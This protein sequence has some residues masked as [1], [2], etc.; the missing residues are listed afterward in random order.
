MC[1]YCSGNNY[2][3]DHKCNVVGCTAKQQLLCG[4]M[5]E[6]CIKHIGNQIVFSSSC[7]KMSEAAKAVLERSTLNSGR[8]P[9][10]SG[11]IHMTTTIIRVVLYCRLR[12]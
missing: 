7:R 6:K 8:Q 2:R 3:N 12:G 10:M 1:G 11:E 4:H 9:P 5:L